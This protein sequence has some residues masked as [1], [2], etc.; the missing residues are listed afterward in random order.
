MNDKIYKNAS[1]HD[2]YMYIMTISIPKTDP[3]NTVLA[4]C[5]C[6]QKT[7]C[8]SLMLIKLSQGTIP[9]TVP[10]I[11]NGFRDIRYDHFSCKIL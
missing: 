3:S 11:S 6:K 10:Y 1:M 8:V 4:V 2:N 5:S 7:A 9:T